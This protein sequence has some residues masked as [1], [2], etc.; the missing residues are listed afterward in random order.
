MDLHKTL[1][2]HFNADLGDVATHVDP[3]SNLETY[4]APQVRKTRSIKLQV[5]A[6]EGGPL[7]GTEPM[8]LIQ[9]APDKRLL[10]QYR[11]RTW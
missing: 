9:M 3:D 6:G 11:H 2:G 7:C 5:G 8:T 1:S 4:Y 10:N